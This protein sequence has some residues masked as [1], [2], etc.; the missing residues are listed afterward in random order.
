MWADPESTRAPSIGE[1]DRTEGYAAST[2]ELAH[3]ILVGKVL[4]N[5]ASLL[6]LLPVIWLVLTGWL[7]IQDN[8]AGNLQNASGMTWFAVKAGVVA[9]GSLLVAG[10]LAGVDR[11]R[12]Q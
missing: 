7:F 1:P 10:V 5:P 8:A 2:P 3:R 12:R 6:I 4:I 11:V 9:L